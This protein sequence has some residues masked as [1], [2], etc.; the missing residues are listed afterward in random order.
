MPLLHFTKQ[1]C[2][3][4][5]AL[6]EREVAESNTGSSESNGSDTVRPFAKVPQDIDEYGYLADTY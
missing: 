5:I 6:L 2:L 1:Y 3:P 4:L